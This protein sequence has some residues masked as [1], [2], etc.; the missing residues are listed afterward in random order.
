MAV[1]PE[2]AE[3]DVARDG[4][5]HRAPEA[6]RT[7]I[8]ARLST[9]AR[10]R[11]RQLW[12]RGGGLAAAFATVA[13]IAFNVGVMHSRGVDDERVAR[14]VVAAH[15]RSLMVDGHLHDVASSDQH[16]VKPW[17]AGRIDFVPKVVDL[18]P[19]GFALIGGRLDYVDGRPVAALAYR[20]RQHIVNVFEWVAPAGPDLPAQ[21]QALR[22]YSLLRWSRGG[23]VF[24]AVSDA[25]IAELELL[26]RELSTSQ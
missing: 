25:S 10:E 16:T 7:R 9:G 12:W 17:F 2:S 18:A 6:L 26:A 19:A 1:K 8:R 5:Y 3:P 20:R 21:S 22:G 23:L 14:D 11:A 13:A 24:Q 15:V 4:T